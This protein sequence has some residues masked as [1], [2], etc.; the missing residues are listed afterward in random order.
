MPSQRPQKYYVVIKGRRP[1]IYYNWIEAGPKVVGLYGAKHE[2][3]PSYAE[4]LE[5]WQKAQRSGWVRVLGAPPPSSRPLGPSASLSALDD[6]KSSRSFSN[7]T[8]YVVAHGREPGVYSNWTEASMQVEGIPDAI[9]QGFC[10]R[11]EAWRVYEGARLRGEVQVI[12]DNPSRQ[13]SSYYQTPEE[14]MSTPPLTPPA[15]KRKGLPVVDE[16]DHHDFSFR[17]SQLNVSPG[18]SSARGQSSFYQTTGHVTP[19]Q[20]EEETYTPPRKLAQHHSLPTTRLPSFDGLPP[21]ARASSDQGAFSPQV[22]EEDSL[23][24]SSSVGIGPPPGVKGYEECKKLIRRNREPPLSPLDNSSLSLRSMDSP[25]LKPASSPS[26]SRKPWTDLSP[27]SQEVVIG[28]QSPSQLFSSTRS[29]QQGGPSKSFTPI[30]RT[31]QVVAVTQS[32]SRPFASP[33]STPGRTRKHSGNTTFS[34]LIRTSVPSP[35]QSFSAPS[36]T[37]VFSKK[38]D[39]DVTFSPLPFDF[40]KGTSRKSR[41]NSPSMSSFGLAPMSAPHSV[42]ESEFDPRSPMFKVVNVPN[43]PLSMNSASFGRPSPAY[44]KN[45]LPAFNGTLL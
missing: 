14:A 5:I 7:R 10:S 29:P 39:G 33:S 23:R 30:A 11:D 31:P 16:R 43:L 21:I 41:N 25:H 15:P 27:R 9:Y 34:P 6:R 22:K 26:P 44:P 36:T 35:S 17:F 32:P 13:Q 18:N 37:P 42:Y 40:G 38:G 12:D 2:S 45:I 3:F 20:G 24:R 1:G 4:A 8:H 28:A 19:N